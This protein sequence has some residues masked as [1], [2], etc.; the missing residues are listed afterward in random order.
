MSYIKF[1]Y[2]WKKKIDEKIR[3]ISIALIIDHS[4]IVY[5]GT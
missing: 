3:W 2:N 5:Y 1:N 4:P